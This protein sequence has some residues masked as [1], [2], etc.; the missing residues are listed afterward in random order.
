MNA[1]AVE[2][3]EPKKKPMQEERSVTYKPL[4]S[5]KEVELKFGF[6]RKYLCT[7]TKSGLLPSDEDIV[8]FLKLCERQALDPWVGDS[9]LTGYDTYDK[10][11]RATVAKFSL[12]TAIQ[13]LL[14]RAELS[15]EFDGLESGVLVIKKDSD[16]IVERRGTVVLVNESL[17]GAYSRCWRKDR[18]H[19]YF[20]T[21][22]FETYN[23]GYSRWEKDPAGMIVKCAKAAVLREAF[24]THLA[25]MYTQE[26][27]DQVVIG[28][29]APHDEQKMIAEKLAPA[30]TSKAKTGADLTEILK[31][32]NG[33]QSET[34]ARKQEN[35]IADTDKM[36]EPDYEATS[37][38][39]F[40][41]SLMAEM[42]DLRDPH[43]V[44][45]IEADIQTNEFSD[46]QK[47]LL[48]VSLA[49]VKKKLVI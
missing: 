41:A 11:T 8:K 44:E 47:A 27:M 46:D 10:N 24:P 38:S 45:Q 42:A 36:V 15:P 28:E 9:F 6:V 43:T 23:T 19:E 33:G 30:I 29:A 14:K 4:G 31:A 20:Q 18:K 37:E 21:V 7:P 5:T 32:R 26:E 17:V 13:A 1:N 2:E 22:Q 39:D 35:H 16:G 48:L 25:G 34:V 3:K 49:K 12:I 40:F